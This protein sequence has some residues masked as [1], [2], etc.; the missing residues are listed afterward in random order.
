MPTTAACATRAPRCARVRGA[1]VSLRKM[2]ARAK[3]LL[4]DYDV[5]L[6]WENGTPESAKMVSDTIY[7]NS[8]PTP[9]IGV[10]PLVDA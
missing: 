7:L 6:P 9:F 1:A 8:T 4:R 2:I 10:R 3:G 5:D